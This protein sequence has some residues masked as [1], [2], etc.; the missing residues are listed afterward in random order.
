MKKLF[1]NIIGV[2]CLAGSLSSCADF[3]EIKPQN[4]IVLEH[5]WSEKADVDNMVSGCYAALESDAAVRRMMMWGEFRSDNVMAGI[6][7]QK[8]MNLYNVFR[9]NITPKNWYTNW[10]I[11]YQVINRCML[12]EC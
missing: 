8:D 11:F 1:Y 3:L 10:S 5:F 9:E 6:D 4:E 7:T 2:A 12:R